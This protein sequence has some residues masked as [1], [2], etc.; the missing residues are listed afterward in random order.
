MFEP[1][2]DNA[3]PTISGT[4]EYHKQ[5]VIHTPK[6]ADFTS[7]TEQVDASGQ[8]SR[9]TLDAINPSRYG[10]GFETRLD[11]GFDLKGKRL[12]SSVGA[13]GSGQAKN[14]VVIPAGWRCSCIRSRMRTFCRA[15]GTQST[16][17]CRRR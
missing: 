11:L 10:R 16:M 8:V 12:L 4:A 1:Y 2:S 13:A 5:Q 15:C 17:P 7:L 14:P 9:F 6:A 3:E